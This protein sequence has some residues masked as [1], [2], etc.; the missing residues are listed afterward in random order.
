V[1][2]GDWDVWGYT[3]ISNAG[4]TTYTLFSTGI[5]LTNSV[6]GAQVMSMNLS[7]AGGAYS[8]VAPMQRI[9]VASTTTVFL[10][11]SATFTGGTPTASGAIYARRAR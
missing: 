6:L 9:S 11:G 5:S 7:I 8:F 2:A 10:V 3:A 1:T 4:A